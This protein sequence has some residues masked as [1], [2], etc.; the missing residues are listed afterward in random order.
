MAN[1]NRDWYVERKQG[2]STREVGVVRF[3][4]VVD[5]NFHF[6]GLVR[7]VDVSATESAIPHAGVRCVMGGSHCHRCSIITWHGQT[8]RM[9]SQRGT[10][11]TAHAL[12]HQLK[13]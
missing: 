12:N 7:S 13:T 9:V 10:K 5:D 1:H 11:T 3:Q 8:L 4:F 6:V 2:T